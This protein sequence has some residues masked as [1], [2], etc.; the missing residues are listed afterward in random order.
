[1]PTQETKYLQTFH[2]PTGNVVVV[3]VTDSIERIG[4]VA[5][6]DKDVSVEI[7]GLRNLPRVAE[8][9]THPWCGDNGNPE[10]L[11]PKTHPDKIGRAKKISRT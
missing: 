7:L 5:L 9:Q 1:M 10:C 4:L 3:S 2:R 6:L 11:C 8:A